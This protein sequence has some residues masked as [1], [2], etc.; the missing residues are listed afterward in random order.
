MKDDSER[1]KETEDFYLAVKKKIKDFERE[2]EYK[3]NNFIEL[4]QKCLNRL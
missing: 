2:T 4:K 1:C 3:F